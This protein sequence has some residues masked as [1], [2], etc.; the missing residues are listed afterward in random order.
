MDLKAVPAVGN[1]SAA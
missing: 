1:S